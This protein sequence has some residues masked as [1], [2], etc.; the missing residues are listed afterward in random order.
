MSVKSK[1]E[2]ITIAVVI[3][4][5]SFLATSG[6]YA[7]YFTFLSLN[8]YPSGYGLDLFAGL[9]FATII[10]TATIAMCFVV[11]KG[12]VRALIGRSGKLFWLFLILALFLVPVAPSFTSFKV[13]CGPINYG[14]YK[15]MVNG[16]YVNPPTG[17]WTPEIQIYRLDSPF[18]AALGIGVTYG[19][20][21][22]ADPIPN[23]WPVDGFRLIAWNHTLAGP[24]PPAN[25]P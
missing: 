8:S 4:I 13:N 20:Y 23:A 21:F 7:V 10:T 5:C 14:S 22:T 2:F 25:C 17:N 3:G 1:T 11:F 18:Y 19:A 15:T 6:F 12:G 16:T 24:V 9:C